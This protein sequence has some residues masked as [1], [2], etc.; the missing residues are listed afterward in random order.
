MDYNKLIEY[1]KFHANYDMK[2]AESLLKS[3]RYPYCLFMCQLALEKVLKAIVVQKIK[4]HAPYTHDLVRLARIIE[5]EFS[6]E[7]MSYLKEI[8]G[9]NIE[10]RYDNIKMEFHKKATKSFTEKYFKI[11]N[12]LYLWLEENFLKK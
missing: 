5:I 4:T 6:K 10:A 12:E 2:T 8:S 11:S 7:Q 1:W 3:K 9:F